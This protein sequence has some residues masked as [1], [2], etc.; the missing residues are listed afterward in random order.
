MQTLLDYR[1]DDKHPSKEMF[2][3]NAYWCQIVF[4]GDVLAPM[5]FGQDVP[6]EEQNALVTVIGSHRSKSVDFPVY[7]IDA[8]WGT[9]ILRNNLHNWNVTVYSKVGPLDVDTEGILYEGH[10]EYLFFEGMDGHNLP[11][12]PETKDSFSFCIG[13]DFSLYTLLFLFRR[14]ALAKSKD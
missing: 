6:Y 3:Y 4:V 2:A 14:A 11:P 13:S 1:R 12:Y 9:L 7:Q 10:G 8:P 5:I